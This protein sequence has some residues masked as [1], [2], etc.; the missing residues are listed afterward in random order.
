MIVMWDAVKDSL[1]I[2]NIICT[3][4]AFAIP[5]VVYKINQR[6]HKYGDPPWKKQE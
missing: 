2:I 4:L 1:S 6:L 3:A 5:Y